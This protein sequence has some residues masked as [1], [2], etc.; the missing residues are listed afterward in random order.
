MLTVY[1]QNVNSFSKISVPCQS[2]NARPEQQR[3]EKTESLAG[4]GE[5]A[6]AADGGSIVG[7]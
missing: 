6:S 3:G 4:T 7:S 5:S 2:G 1:N